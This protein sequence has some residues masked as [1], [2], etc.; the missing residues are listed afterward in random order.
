MIKNNFPKNMEEYKGGKSDGWCFRI[1]LW[2][3]TENKVIEMIKEFLNNEGY[4]DIPI[5]KAERLWWDY[6]RPDSNGIEGSF[7]WYPIQ[8]YQNSYKK[9]AVSLFI[10]NENHPEHQKLWNDICKD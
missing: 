8:I 10:Y 4:S 5:P 9:N 7:I 6:L 3:E 1:D 2:A